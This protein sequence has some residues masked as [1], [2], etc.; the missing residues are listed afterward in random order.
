MEYCQ[1]GDAASSQSSSERQG[2]RYVSLLI[3]TSRQVSRALTNAGSLSGRIIF[4]SSTVQY[5]GTHLN[6]HGVVAKAGIDALSAQLAIELGPRGTT[7]NVIAPGP[8]SG[9][10]GVRRLFDEGSGSDKR[11]I[12]LGRFGC[13]KDMGDAAVYL[14]SDAGSYVT[15]SVLVGT[16]R[17]CSSV[18]FMT[19]TSLT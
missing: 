12:P 7:F 11:K 17:L 14:F 18:L 3:Q 6:T 15:G 13:L 9:T 10:E 2:N 8:I 4:I 1:G 19:R 5:T 16:Y